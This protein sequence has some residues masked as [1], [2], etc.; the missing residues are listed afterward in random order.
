M[1]ITVQAAQ[2]KTEGQSFKVFVFEP[3]ANGT[4]LRGTCLWVSVMGGTE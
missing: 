2:N 3:V 4:E 1:W